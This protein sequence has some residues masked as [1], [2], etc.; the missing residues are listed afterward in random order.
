M[1]WMVRSF[2]LVVVGKV[3][4]L[5]V[6]L[7]VVSREDV[8][9]VSVNLVGSLVVDNTELSSVFVVVSLLILMTSVEVSVV[10]GISLCNISSMNGLFLVAVPLIPVST[11]V[12]EY[13]M[14]GKGRY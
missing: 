13:S 4:V 3:G 2:L 9:G 1:I 6:L 14:V 11:S 8:L 10:L 7:F 5:G 12:K